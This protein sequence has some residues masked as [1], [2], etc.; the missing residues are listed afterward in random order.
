MNPVMS[1]EIVRMVHESMLEEH[2]QRH[3][4]PRTPNIV[5]HGLAVLLV[6]LG[7]RLDPSL[8]RPAIPARTVARLHAA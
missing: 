4:H 3:M 6:T 5:R 8:R 2:A 1:S 7:N